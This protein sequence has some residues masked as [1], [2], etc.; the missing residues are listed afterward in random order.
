LISTIL[1]HNRVP[2]ESWDGVI[3]LPKL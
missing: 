1:R 3:D 2:P